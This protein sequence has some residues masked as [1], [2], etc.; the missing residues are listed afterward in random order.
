VA[1]T[2]LPLAELKA[3]GRPLSA[4]VNDVLL[5]VVAGALRRYLGPRGELPVEPLVAA[6]PFSTHVEGEEQANAVT[7]GSVSLATH[8]DDPAERLAAIRD[9]SLNAKRHRR[10]ALGDHM[11]EWMDVPPPLV[12]SLVARAYTGL[13]LVDRMPLLCNLLVSSVNGPPS[14]LYFAGA[15]LV[16]LY[17]LGPVYDGMALNVTALRCGDS[18]DVGLVACRGLIRD[19]WEIADAMPEALSELTK[20]GRAR[21]RR[22]RAS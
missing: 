2:G 16:G 12:F 20:S 13:G 10:S 11:A 14:A 8:L 19:L 5:A 3:A 9:A 15:R 22:A 17:P 4:T 7:S 6:V 18:L 21:A 1:Y